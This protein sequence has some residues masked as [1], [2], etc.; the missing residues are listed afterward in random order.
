MYPKNLSTSFPLRLQSQ[1]DRPRRLIP[2]RASVRMS[3]SWSSSSEAQGLLLFSTMGVGL[4]NFADGNERQHGK[5]RKSYYHRATPSIHSSY[6]MAAIKTFRA[7]TM[8]IRLEVWARLSLS[9]G[10]SLR[11]LRL[12]PQLYSLLRLPRER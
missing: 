11:P 1:L 10:Q 3:R 2:K 7:Q 12:Q 4:A 5:D 9:N 8:P 6:C